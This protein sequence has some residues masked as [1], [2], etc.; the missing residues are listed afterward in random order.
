M[1]LASLTVTPGMEPYSVNGL[2]QTS[3]KLSNN[4]NVGVEFYDGNTYDQS[5]STDVLIVEMRKWIIFAEELPFGIDWA[6]SPEDCKSM[7]P[8]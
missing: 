1:R 6:R 5:S 4:D 8:G 3:E 2:L 7:T